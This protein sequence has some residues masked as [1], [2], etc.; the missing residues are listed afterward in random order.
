MSTQKKIITIL[1]ADDHQMTR[2][3]CRTILDKV[4]DMKIVGEAQD[5]DEI[6]QLVK[7]LKPQILLLDLKMPHLSPAALE[8]WVRINYPETSTLILTSHDRDFYLSA[9]ID[10][11]AAGYFDKKIRASQLVSAIRRAAN[12]EILFDK[13]QIERA[14]LWRQA[15]G[16]KWSSLSNREKEVLQILTEGADNY[17]IAASLNVTIDTVEKH[18][19]NIYKKLGVKSRMEATLWWLEKGRDFRN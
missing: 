16:S 17:G 4:P 10:A 15:I 14:R 2:Q 7:K 5:G 6:K 1:L 19:T 3:G 9:M 13:D 8:E 12:G 11:G 18:L